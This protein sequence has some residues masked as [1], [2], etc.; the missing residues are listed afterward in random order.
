MQ[1]SQSLQRLNYCKTHLFLFLKSSGV[2]IT[3]LNSINFSLKPEFRTLANIIKCLSDKS[4]PHLPTLVS[5]V[6]QHVKWIIVSLVK[7]R[8]KGANYRQSWYRLCESSYQVHSDII[9]VPCKMA[10]AYYKINSAKRPCTYNTV[11]TYFKC[12]LWCL[13][14]NR[15]SIWL[16]LR[17]RLMALFLNCHFTILLLIF[18]L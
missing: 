5:W 15:S 8:G 18:P 13:P 10:S 7:D 2:G 16:S 9:T 6:K 11:N 12:S 3:C 14:S 1:E 4:S 17:Q